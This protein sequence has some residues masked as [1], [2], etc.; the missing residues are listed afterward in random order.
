MLFFKKKKKLLRKATEEDEKSFAAAMEE[1]N[2]G[3]KDK[4]AMVISAFLVI[5]LP[6][7]L[8]LLAISGI[9]LLLF[10]GFN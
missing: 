7:L 4:L 10:G 6:C 2:V 3:F 1:N 5:V 8:I 9:A